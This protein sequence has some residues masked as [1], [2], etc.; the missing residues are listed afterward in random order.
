MITIN[1]ILDKEIISYLQAHDPVVR[2]YRAFF[3]VI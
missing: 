2:E 3:R 1:T